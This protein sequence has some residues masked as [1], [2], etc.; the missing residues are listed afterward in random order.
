MQHDP[1]FP[2]RFRHRDHGVPADE[3]GLLTGAAGIAL[4]LADPA[5]LP[6]PD[7]PTPWTAAL[8]LPSPVS[9]PASG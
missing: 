9:V 3:P 8:L 6:A 7:V 4:A 2:F 5:I 1:R